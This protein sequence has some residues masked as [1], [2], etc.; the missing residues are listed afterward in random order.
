MPL[1]DGVFVVSFCCFFINFFFFSIIESTGSIRENLNANPVL[2]VKAIDD[3]AEINA[4]ITYGITGGNFKSYFSIDSQTGWINSTTSIDFE[5]EQ[6]FNLTVSASDSKYTSYARVAIEVLNEND[7]NPKFKQSRFYVSVA[8][9]SPV[10]TSVTTILASD[11]DSFGQLSYSIESVQPAN[12]SDT[13][14]VD[15]T[16]GVITTADDLDRE[17]ID[18]YVLQVKVVD[19]GEPQLSDFAMVIVD[20]TDMNDN[21]PEFSVS[22]MQAFLPE[23]AGVGS[24][25]AKIFATDADFGINANIS[26]SINS[27]TDMSAFVIS[28][29]TGS[30]ATNK[31]LDRENISSYVLICQARDHGQPQLGSMP[32]MIHVSLTDVNDNAP[33]FQQSAYAVNISEDASTGSVV[34][35][36][37]AVDP[38]V[39]LNGKVVYG[40]SGGNEGGAFIIGNRTGENLCSSIH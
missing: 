19:S 37:L 1:L 38:D 3:D 30:I 17:L 31:K 23:D 24:L 13:F 4:Q 34:E 2:Q 32:I 16:S 12:Q 33:V 20:I 7:N 18:R 27:S 14:S 29:E 9:N 40:I 10:L 5:Q 26:Y 8:E 6:R 21:P 15:L 36:V 25:V 28:T 11:V 39:G 22:T 35:E